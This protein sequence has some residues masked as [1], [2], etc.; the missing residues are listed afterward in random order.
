MSER[1]IHAIVTMDVSVSLP[2][3]DPEQVTADPSRK[4]SDGEL[5]E[6]IIRDIFPRE[7]TRTIYFTENGP[8]S[9]YVRH[10]DV[11]IDGEEDL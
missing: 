7:R 5:A 2:V 1:T 9:V 6:S 4:M 10:I 3:N 11:R 8:R